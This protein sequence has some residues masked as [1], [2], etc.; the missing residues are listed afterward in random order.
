MLRV[1]VKLISGKPSERKLEAGRKTV[2]DNLTR[3][4]EATG[5]SKVSRTGDMRYDNRSMAISTI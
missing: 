5:N 4:I 3:A 1:N 2:K